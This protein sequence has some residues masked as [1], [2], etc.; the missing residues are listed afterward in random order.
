MK[1]VVETCKLI[2]ILEGA[3]PSIGYGKAT[4]PVQL[5][6]VTKYMERAKAGK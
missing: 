4:E 5:D 1:T 2:K 6:F 3:E